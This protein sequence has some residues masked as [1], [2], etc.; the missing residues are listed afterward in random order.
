MTSERVD[1]GGVSNIAQLLQ[2][3][4]PANT[5]ARP[6]HRLCHFI[7]PVCIFLM[8]TG[9]G[10]PAIRGS[11]WSLHLQSAFGSVASAVSAA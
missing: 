8:Y 3:M 9:L 1:A 2:S 11:I 4:P 6:Y 10:S 7:A 5:Q